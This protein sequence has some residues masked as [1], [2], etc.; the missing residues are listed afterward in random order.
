V[1]ASADYV[2]TRKD[3]LIGSANY[4]ILQHDKEIETLDRETVDAGLTWSREL[5]PQ[6]TFSTLNLRQRRIM[7]DK[8]LV[9]TPQIDYLGKSA[10]VDE[11]EMSAGLTH[12]FNQ[13]WQGNVEAGVTYSQPDFPDKNVTVPPVTTLEK[14]PNEATL[15]PLF[16]AGMVFSP[17]P[18]TRLTGN[19]ALSHQA[20]DNDGYGG[21]DTSEL[22]F[23]AQHDLTAKLMAKATARFANTTYDSQDNVTK[24]KADRAGT[25]EDRMDFEFMLT[26]KL[27]RMNFIEMSAMHR[28]K[29]SDADDASWAENRVSVGWRLELN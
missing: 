11:T 23:S 18:R 21:Q 25:T 24:A 7:Y 1:G 16:R 27:N 29:D 15:S 22:S 9:D 5:S 28:E 2:L 17:S 14:E 20:S 3:R 12:T 6:R 4:E 19:F 26:Y 8:M 13:Q 10:Y